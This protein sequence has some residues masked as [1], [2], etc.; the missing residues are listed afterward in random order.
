[1]EKIDVNTLSKRCAYHAVKRVFD[2]VACGGAPVVLS[3]VML[4][5]AAA[6]KLDSPGPVIFKQECLGRN[7]K[8]F[9]IHK[10]RSMR[11]DAEVEGAK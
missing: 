10:F 11:A 3:P 5:V 1:M 2:V 8:P 9:Y 6:V 4:G 7:R